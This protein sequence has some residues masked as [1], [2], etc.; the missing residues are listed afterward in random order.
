MTTTK[1]DARNHS[2]WPELKGI[3]RYAGASRD[4]S[5]DNGLD[6]TCRGGED[7]P[8]CRLQKR[9]M[10][11]A[12][13]E[14]AIQLLVVD[15]GDRWLYWTGAVT[16]VICG[17]AT[18]GTYSV[19]DELSPASRGA[20]FTA[21]D[22]FATAAYI[23]YVLARSR[24]SLFTYRVHIPIPGP[25][26]EG[27]PLDWSYF[28]S[29]ALPA[30]DIEA[31]AFAAGGKRAQFASRAAFRYQGA[32]DAAQARVQCR[33]AIEY[34]RVQLRSAGQRGTADKVE[35]TNRIA[36]AAAEIDAANDILATASSV[37]ASNGVDRARLTEVVAGEAGL[38]ADAR[39]IEVA[40]R[41]LKSRATLRA[42]DRG[43]VPPDPAWVEQSGVALEAALP[44]LEAAA[45]RIGSAVAALRSL[46]E[47][48]RAKAIEMRVL[49][50]PR[51]AA[52]VE[53]AL[54]EL[55]ATDN[56]VSAM[57]A[58]RL[59]TDD[60]A[61]RVDSVL[62]VASAIMDNT[63]LPSIRGG[64]A[65]VKDITDAVYG[66]LYALMAC[67][68][69][70]IV[71][72]LYESKYLASIAHTLMNT[73]NDWDA[74]AEKAQE[75]L[76]IAVAVMIVAAAGYQLNGLNKKWYMDIIARENLTERLGDSLRTMARMGGVRSVLT[77][78]AEFMRLLDELDA[79]MAQDVLSDKF[80]EA[81]APV[82][83]SSTV[84]S[85]TAIVGTLVC[86]WFLWRHVKPYARLKRMHDLTA[87]MH[88]A[89]GPQLGGAPV[90][91]AILE[92]Q[93]AL[94]LDAETQIFLPT[95]LKAV[96]SLSALVALIYYLVLMIM[97]EN[98]TTQL[99]TDR[100]RLTSEVAAA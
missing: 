57:S 48:L 23:F 91:D 94:D 50:D 83:I 6:K 20:F 64:G 77:E 17:L 49:N 30:S 15:T 40:S 4:A 24:A 88:A 55:P 99:Y 16:C 51:Y 9:L 63:V 89:P 8:I 32:L 92:A 82:R 7:T 59:M 44:Q 27:A 74:T 47:Q 42:G 10:Q 62:S 58:V 84:L 1:G 41:V 25:G 65:R 76:K 22:F 2:I 96:V 18:A 5:A 67:W 26:G 38:T 46:G 14:R 80:A 100:L 12:T 85:V 13:L 3:V 71:V 61:L 19:S 11:P 52:V 90:P 93:E 98:R 60:D 35:D 66:A 34:F 56:G 70:V 54:S 86:M 81:Y 43:S 39:W 69:V 87:P 75:L 79:V 68:G 28:I 73:A 45:A 72:A 31:L 53:E 97:T 29:A 33:D 78:Q 95:P 37:L 36:Y 21:E